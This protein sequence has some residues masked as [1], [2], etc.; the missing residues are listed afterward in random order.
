[1]AAE[2]PGDGPVLVA[3][4]P[5]AV[6]LHTTQPEGTPRNVWK[7]TVAEVEGFGERRRVRL[8]GAVPVVA[9]ITLDGADGAAAGAGRRGVG[10][11]QGHRAAGVPRVGLG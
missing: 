9:E 7:G 5:S 8:A 11:R 6:A 4:R 2:A 3:I 10:Q 1:M